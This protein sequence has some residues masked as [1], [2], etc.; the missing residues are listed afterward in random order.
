MQGSV[1]RTNPLRTAKLTEEQI[2]ELLAF[3]LGDGG[4]GV[5]RDAVR[6]PDG[7]RRRDDAPSRSTPAASR[8]PSTSTRSASRS[9]GVPDM[10]ARQA[11]NALATRLARLRPGWLDRDRRLR[12]DGLP[13]HPHG[14]DRHGRS[15]TSIAWPWEDIAATDFE[16]PADPNAFQLATRTLTPARGRG[17]RRRR[18]RRR[19]PRA[20]S[21]AAPA[22]ASSTR[23]RCARC[24]PDETE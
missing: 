21:S 14:R 7:H 8:R 23:S 24:C 17:A 6:Q 4:L 20:C 15:R 11:F 22:T 18:S 9:E 3:A 2:Q 13:R 10:P 1:M 16:G 12:A 5:A 19:V